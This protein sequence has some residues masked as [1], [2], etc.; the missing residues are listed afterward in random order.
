MAEL[1]A[2]VEVSE[3]PKPVTLQTLIEKKRDGVPIVFTT[4]YASWQARLADEAGI[5]GLVIGDSAAHV[6]D[7]YPSTVPMRLPEMLERCSAVWRGTKRC[8]RI[9]DAP[10]GTT[11]EGPEQAVRTAVEFIRH[12]CDAVKVEGASGS[13]LTQIKAIADAGIL[14]M[15]HVGLTPQSRARFGGYKVQGRT[16]ETAQR[17]AEDAYMVERAGVALLLVE[18]VPPEVGERV[19]NAVRIPVIGVGAGPQVDGQTVIVHDL[20]G[21]FDQFR[22]KFAK[23][24][25]EGAALVR[26]ALVDYAADVRGRRFPAAEHR[27]E[28]VPGEREKLG[29]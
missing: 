29:K 7:G 9:G 21:L 10:F 12:G 27:Y 17:I 26:N 2:E 6:E 4:A 16:V 28:M 20:L 24:Y 23:R 5:D 8:F 13:R 3:M 18:A 15:G 19:R 11:E 14:V 25:L 22:P 1:H